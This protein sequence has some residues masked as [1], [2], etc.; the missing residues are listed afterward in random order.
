VSHDCAI[1]NCTRPAKDHQLMCWPHWCRVPKAL[2]RAV[3]AAYRNLRSDPGTYRA[4]RGAAV[5]A[6]VAKETAEGPTATHICVDPA[7]RKR[8]TPDEPLC[9]DCR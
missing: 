4:A 3:F 6:V 8:T 1:P 5:A 7:C 9:R 2:N